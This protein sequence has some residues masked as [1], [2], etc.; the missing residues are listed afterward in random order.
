VLA[1][2]VAGACAATELPT[3]LSL[4]EVVDAAT[5]QRGEVDAAELGVA[6]ARERPAIA[7]ALD[8][9]MVMAGI[10]HY[11]YRSMPPPMGSSGDA[12]P[13]ENGGRRYDWSVQV[14]QR[15]PLSRLRQHR[16]RAAEA[17][18]DVARAEA[19]AVRADVALQAAEAFHMLRE[20]R[21]MLAVRSRQLD[22]AD[23]L[24][25][26]TG[27]RLAAAVGSQGDVL[28]AEVERAR[29][30]GERQATLAAARGARAMLNGALGRPASARVPRLVQP[31]TAPT[32]TVHWIEQAMA[33]RPELARMDAEVSR[34]GAELDVMRAMGRPMGLVRI[35]E[36]STMAEGRGAML[37]LGVSVPLGRQRVRAGIAEARAMQAMA[38]AERDA[39]QRMIIAEAVAAREAVAAA[40]VRRDAYRDDIVPR[41]RRAVDPALAAYASG[42]GSLLLVIEAA[43]L[44]WRVEE[45]LL[46]AETELGRASARLDRAVGLGVRNRGEVR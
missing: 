19:D 14:E 36:A 20:Q 6:A 10:D 24:V 23:E 8:D 15:F 1:L 26:I 46:M 44:K 31:E 32:P 5:R 28:R 45:E 25:V 38:E 33:Q 37:M 2:L 35:G 29:I 34:T 3:P 40:R 18:V 22:L 16:R 17:G 42:G 12:M 11:P 27:R 21:R 4:E 30:A 39:M 7:G 9:P 43:Q 13:I 41:A